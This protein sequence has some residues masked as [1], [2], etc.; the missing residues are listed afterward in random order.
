MNEIAS[1]ALPADLPRFVKDYPEY[2]LVYQKISSPAG[3]WVVQ[4]NFM[5][6]GWGDHAELL[7]DE[8]FWQGNAFEF[9]SS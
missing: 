1:K 3:V 9:C 8:C 5:A 4:G 2:I 7:I 6:P